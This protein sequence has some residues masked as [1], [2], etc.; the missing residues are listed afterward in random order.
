MELSV[1]GEWHHRPRLDYVAE[2][3]ASTGGTVRRNSGLGGLLSATENN[4]STEV[5]LILGVTE[6]VRDHWKLEQGIAGRSDGT[7]VILLGW[8]YNFNQDR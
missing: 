1:S 5:E 6:R 7:F 3:T 4:G 8:E 2:L